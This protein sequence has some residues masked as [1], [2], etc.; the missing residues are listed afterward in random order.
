MDRIYALWTFVVLVATTLS[1]PVMAADPPQTTPK[2]A[3]VS[4][5]QMSSGQQ[6]LAGLKQQVIALNRELFLLEQ[7]LL[8][9]PETQLGL[10]VTVDQGKF[11]QLQ[12]VQL[13]LDDEPVGSHLYTETELTALANGAVQP[14]LQTNVDAG[15]HRLTAI[16]TGKG[17]NNR[18]YRRAVSYEFEKGSEGVRLE[19][20]V[21]DDAGN[22]QPSF[23]I[24]P[25]TQ[26]H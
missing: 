13:L 9:P 7:A 10:Y 23:Q 8:Y 3:D 4:S 19:L 20:Q 14:L 21:N 17:P 6:E 11:F 16:F 25:W 18:E 22:Y 12:G 26:A 1:L 15:K 24:L 2:S 5:A